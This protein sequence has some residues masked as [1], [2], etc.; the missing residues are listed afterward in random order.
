MFKYIIVPVTGANTDAP[1]LATALSIAR[2]GAAH[3][4]FLHARLDIEQVLSSALA[5]GELAGIIGYEQ[6]AKSLQEDTVARQRRAELAFRILCER[7]RL[8]ERAEAS[9]ELSAELLIATGDQ[10]KLLAEHGRAADLVVV[11]RLNEG[12]RLAIGLVEATLMATGRPILIASEKEPRDI[13]G[14]IAIAWK[15]RPEAARAVAAALPLIERAKRV[16]ILSVKEDTPLD[17]RSCSRLRHALSWHNEDVHVK[18]LRPEDMAPVETLLY[19]V[20]AV[21][22]DLLVMGGYGHSRT[23]EFMFGGFTRRVLQG[24]DLPVLMTH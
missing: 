20:K 5:V 3:L 2:P 18:I 24:A 23:R 4:E 8:V 6:L 12:G 21:Q 16:V 1:V 22:A 19:A 17:A 11:G 15:D 9:N 7:E 13:A 14:T 10:A